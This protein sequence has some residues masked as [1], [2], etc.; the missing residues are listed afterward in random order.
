VARAHGT[1]RRTVLLESSGAPSASAAAPLEVADDPCWLLLSS[2]GLLARTATADPLE[3]G[4]PDQ[5]AAH[6]VLRSAVRT[7]VR[8]EVAAVTNRGRM[9]RL[10]VVDTPALPPTAGPPSLSGGA[11]LSE[12]L[13][14]EPGEHVLTLA[15]LDADSAGLALGTAAGVV[16]RVVPDYPANRDAWE[17]ISLKDGD[18]VVGAV[19]LSSG[20]EQLVFVTSDAQ[21]LR[22]DASA[23]RPQGRAG[24]GIAGV[25]MAPGARVVSFSAVRDEASAVVVTVSGSSDALPGTEAGNAKVTPL[26]EYPAKGR[27]T[28]GVRCHRFLRGEDALLLAWVGEGP[29]RGAASSGG[30]VELPPATGRRD[31]SGTPLPQPLQAV[32]GPLGTN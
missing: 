7:T 28:G 6:D 26:P 9:L 27:A 17:V 2:T 22:F 13:A 14:L 1:P 4:T 25:R 3:A 5:R 29:A 31:G 24:G 10:G 8:G 12:F 30:A 32:G 20:Q 23:V 19:E 15:G 11:P 21:L 16:K 18:E